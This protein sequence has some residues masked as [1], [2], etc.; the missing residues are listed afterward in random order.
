MAWRENRKTGPDNKEWLFFSWNMRR[1]NGLWSAPYRAPSDGDSLM[2]F[3]ADG[4]RVYFSSSRSGT[5]DI[6]FADRNGKDW[7]EPKC[8]KF[9]SHWPELKFAWVETICAQ[10]YALLHWSRTRPIPRRRHLP[11]RTRQR[12]IHKTAVASAQHQPAA[13][14]ELDV[15]HCP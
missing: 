14:L 13:F 7:G 5:R 11:S 12:R 10:R 15:V 2:L 3:S 4:Q 8:L 1:E 9:V 6:W